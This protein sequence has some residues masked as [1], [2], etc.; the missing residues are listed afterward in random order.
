MYLLYSLMELAR[1]QTLMAMELVVH[2]K[3][4]KENRGEVLPFKREVSLSSV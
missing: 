1:V 3:Q 2:L 4:L